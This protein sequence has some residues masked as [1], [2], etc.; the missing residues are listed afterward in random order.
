MLA[1]TTAA[2]STLMTDSKIHIHSKMQSILLVN[3]IQEILNLLLDKLPSQRARIKSK[4]TVTVNKTI[5]PSGSVGTGSRPTE[6]ALGEKQQK[7]T[8]ERSLDTLCI[9]SKLVIQRHSVSR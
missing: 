7:P 5:H 6:K 1:L 2:V 4:V 9:S 8:D 3:Y